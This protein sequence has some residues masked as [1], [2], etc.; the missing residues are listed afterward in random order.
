M[1]SFLH[2]LSTIQCVTR[3][4][5]RLSIIIPAFNEEK[6]LPHCLASVNEARQRLPAEDIEVIVCDN[7]STDETPT[8]AQAAGATVVF[9]PINQISRARN[10]GARAA[11]GHW[12]LFIDADSRLHP[13]N[14]RRVLEIT[15]SSSTVIGGGATVDVIG[16]PWW[17]RTASWFWRAISVIGKIAAGSFLFCRAD[18]FKQLHG[19]S[20]ELFAAEEIDF[21]RRLK[22]WAHQHRCLFVILTGRPHLSSARKFRLYS[23]REFIR[24]GLL[25]LL[26]YRSLVRNRD[27]LG[28]FYEGR[29]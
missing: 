20:H 24:L 1:P 14:L 2:L 3:L 15:H 5:M 6:E 26:Q 16:G 4:T 11:R 19:F 29:R 17:A 10:T 27:R 9:E 8:V 28:F 22:S 21:S 13:E 7:N 18:V 12:L 23:P 25:A